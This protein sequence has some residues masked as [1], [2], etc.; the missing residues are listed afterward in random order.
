MLS[1][2]SWVSQ[3]VVQN[4][5][6]KK[7]KTK[8]NTKENHAQR[9]T[10]AK[11][12]EGKK[13]LSMARDISIHSVLHRKSDLTKFWWVRGMKTSHRLDTA[14]VNHIMETSITINK[15]RIKMIIWKDS[16]MKQEKI[17]S[18]D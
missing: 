10:C 11:E 7:T 13:I 1:P 12:K 9:H 4:P 15:L 17:E 16:L 18:K 8:K 5:P 3:V 6:L 14:N 2:Y